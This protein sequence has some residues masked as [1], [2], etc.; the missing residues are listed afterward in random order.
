MRTKGL[1]TL[2][3][4]VRRTVSGEPIKRVSFMLTQREAQKAFQDI[5]EILEEEKHA[6][7]K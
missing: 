6:E 7:E 2:S 1:V 4:E 5:V 3:I